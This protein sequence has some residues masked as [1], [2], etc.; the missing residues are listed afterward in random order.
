MKLRRFTAA[1]LTPF[2]VVSAASAHKPVQHPP[3]KHRAQVSALPNIV[4]ILTDDL[5]KNLLPYMPNVQALQDRGMTFTDFTVTDSLCCPSRASIFT[6]EFP[7]NTGVHENG[8]PNGGYQGFADHGDERKSFAVDLHNY[9]YLTEFGGKDFNGYQPCNDPAPGWSTWH[10]VNDGGYNGYGYNMANGTAGHC[11]WYDNDP[12]DYATYQLRT[13]TN[14]FIRNEG[15]TGPFFAEMA[16]FAPHFPSTPAPGDGN[17]YPNLN[18]PHTPAW[19]TEPTNAP[20]WLQKPPMSDDDITR[21]NNSFRQRVRSVQAVDGAVAN[22]ENTLESQGMLGNTYFVFAS[23]NGF[24]TGEYQLLPGKM[25]AFDSDV[26]VPLIVA[27]PGVCHGCVNHKPVSNIDLA[28]TFEDLVGALINKDTI[29]GHSF[30]PLLHG[31]DVPW[32]TFVG[33]EHTNPKDEC[34]PDCQPP[35]AGELPSY[36]ALRTDTFTYVQYKTGEREY[37]DRE[38]DPYELNNIYDTLPDSRKNALKVRADALSSCQ[39]Y[40]D[41]W[42]KAVVTND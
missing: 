4:F 6:G 42:T 17:L 26:N 36:T 24:H 1:A 2:L 12:S 28:P 5:S 31:E 40:S 18:A 16:T 39:G 22:I 34:D 15:N 25:T 20:Q 30:E 3:I 38:A 9:G 19:N 27:G 10:A 11:N 13:Q 7:H 32:R 14:D 41:C 23:D 37:Y 33:I 21:N 8:G 35:G 29:D